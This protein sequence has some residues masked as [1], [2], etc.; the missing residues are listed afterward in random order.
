MTTNKNNP[1]VLYFGTG[2]E[3]TGS[4]IGIYKIQ[5]EWEDGGPVKY[6]ESWGECGW[7]KVCKVLV[8]PDST[9]WIYA[10][11][12][13]SGYC[14]SYGGILISQDGGDTWDDKNTGY[15]N[16]VSN[17]TIAKNNL[18]E[19][20]IFAV[21]GGTW[22]SI[23]SMKLLK[24]T[25]MGETWEEVESP[26]S[27]KIN[28]NVL[29]THPTNPNSIIIGS[30]YN[31]K[32]LWIYNNENDTWNFINGNGLPNSCSP[33][34]FEI[35]D[36]GNTMYLTT[37]YGGIYKYN[38]NENNWNKINIGFNNSFVNDLIVIPNS[39]NTVYASTEEEL[40]PREKYQLI[41]FFLS[42]GNRK[43]IKGIRRVDCEIFLDVAN[44]LFE[45]NRDEQITFFTNF[46][47]GKESILNDKEAPNGLENACRAALMS[48]KVHEA[49]K[50]GAVQQI[51]EN[52]YRGSF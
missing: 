32:P 52:Q 14:N 37:Q 5:N 16:A 29:I 45:R 3:L 39:C 26:Y 49:I 12:I 4:D 28:P 20:T 50:T 30:Y 13:N 36:D 11:G 19:R 35:S 43:R 2:E 22:T 33:T 42:H 18:G 46:F 27:E 38:S 34:S 15:A 17:I 23:S 8:D 31:D 1:D 44:Y 7:S 6:W 51:D 9:N 48:Y 41:L 24:S 21:D 40:K 47:M 10:A 25:D